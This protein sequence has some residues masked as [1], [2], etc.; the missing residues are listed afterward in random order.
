MDCLSWDLDRFQ[1]PSRESTTPFMSFSANLGRKLLQ[2]KHI[3]PNLVERKWQGVLPLTFTL[4]WK[5]VWTKKRTPKE[6]GLLWLTW[7]RAVAVNKWRGRIN[8]AIDLGCHVCPRRS[9]ESV[10]H[11]FWECVSTQ[12]ASQWG[13]HLMNTLITNR[14]A[15]GPLRMLTWKH[16]ISLIKSRASLTKLATSG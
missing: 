7:H 12:R 2:K 1:W 11:R 14:S 6:A 13:I 8:R 15:R 10:L 4:R 3:I 9:E 5:S 16:G